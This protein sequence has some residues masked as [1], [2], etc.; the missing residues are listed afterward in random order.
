MRKATVKTFSIGRSQ[1]NLESLNSAVRMI[2][3]ASDIDDCLVRDR[4]NEAFEFGL[5]KS[6]CSAQRIIRL[7]DDHCAE[8]F[9]CESEEYD[10]VA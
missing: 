6:T 5:D 3:A 10:L 2:C 1:F 7:W 4:L 9:A 8:K